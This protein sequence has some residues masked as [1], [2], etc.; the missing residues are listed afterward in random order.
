[1]RRGAESGL[2]RR[3]SGPAGSL[4]TIQILKA[5][6]V[7]ELGRRDLE[8]V[9][10]LEGLDRVHLAGAVAPRVPFADLGARQ[11]VRAR[12]LGEKQPAAQHIARFV[13]LAMVLE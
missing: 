4:P 3:R 5:H 13:L 10:V 12:S 6:D 11:Q 1:M 7:V 9:R 8:D 2:S